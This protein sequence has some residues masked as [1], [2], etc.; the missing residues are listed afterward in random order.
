MLKTKRKLIPWDK[1]HVGHIMVFET[2]FDDG[3]KE[4]TI[5]AINA[6]DKPHDGK[7]EVYYLLLYTPDNAD[8]LWRTFRRTLVKGKEYYVHLPYY[9]DNHNIK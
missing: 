9:I 2:T 4:V 1:L 7:F 5:G 3:E 6:I 8:R